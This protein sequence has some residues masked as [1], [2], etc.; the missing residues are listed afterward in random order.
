[1]IIVGV[2]VGPGMLTEEAIDT[3]RS[4]PVVYGS[5]R[6]IEI[7]EKYITSEANE[8]KDYKKLHLLPEDAVV[9]ST[10]DPLFSGLGKFARKNDKIIPGISSLHLACARLGVNITDLAA[11]TAHGRGPEHSKNL[12]IQELKLGKNILLLPD[13]SFGSPEVAEVLS[14][15]KIDADIYACEDL[16]YP[17]ERITGG[18]QNNPPEVQSKLYCIMI[19]QK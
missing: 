14:D 4:A 5:K 7:A 8:I 18:T 19:V 3:I 9:L 12:L 10:G 17:E 11:I 15:L 1:M 16:G 13:S 6:A 2:G